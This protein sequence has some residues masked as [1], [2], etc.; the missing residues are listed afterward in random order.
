MKKLLKK[1]LVL[2]PGLD[3]FIDTGILQIKTELFLYIPKVRRIMY[4]HFSFSLFY[5]W[6][7]I[8]NLASPGPN[9]KK[10][11]VVQTFVNQGDT[12]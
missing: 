5:K 6:G 8:I 12:R 2:I 3:M 4:F 9:K 10:G 1:C 11:M 7:I